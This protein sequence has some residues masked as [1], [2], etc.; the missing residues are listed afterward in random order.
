[1]QTDGDCQFNHLF[2][3]LSFAL[4]QPGVP[5]GHH[6]CPTWG[7]GVVLACAWSSAC[8]MFPP[9][10]VMRRGCRPA[11]CGAGSIVTA[12][13]SLG[14]GLVTTWPL[15]TH[16]LLTTSNDW[17]LLLLS[18]RLADGIRRVP[19]LLFSISPTP[20]SPKDTDS[21]VPIEK[22]PDV[23]SLGRSVGEEASLFTWGCSASRQ[24][25]WLSIPPLPSPW[26][27]LFTDFSHHTLFPVD[28]SG[29]KPQSGA[30]CH[31]FGSQVHAKK[32]LL[33]IGYRIAN[34]K[35]T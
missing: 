16:A 7:E 25:R 27:L 26:S 33:R 22:T 2:S 28:R 17:T 4:G 14:R 18:V 21:V 31:S 15:W 9:R 24:C 11:G 3:V 32:S 13:R 10:W 35:F 12:A 23:P 5:E 30:K 29:L 6:I 19:I 8:L 1:M 34:T 20:A